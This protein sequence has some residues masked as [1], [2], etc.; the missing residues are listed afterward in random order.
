MEKVTG[1]QKILMILSILMG[2]GLIVLITY[3]I[4]KDRRSTR[5]KFIDKAKD[6]GSNLPGIKD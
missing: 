5:E 3:F 4:K 6:F 2:F 1:F